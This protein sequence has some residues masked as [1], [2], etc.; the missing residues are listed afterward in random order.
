MKA[1]EVIN[2][3]ATGERD[4][5]GANLRGLSFKNQDLSGAD[6]SG[7]DIRSTNFTGA[8]LTGAKFIEAQA[9]LQKRW[10]ILLVLLSWLM[11]FSSSVFS[12]VITIWIPFFFKPELDLGNVE[13]TITSAIY[14]LIMFVFLIATVGRGLKSGAIAAVGAVIVT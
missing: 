12:W 13:A 10:V 11:A 8:N 1:S 5:R 7:A 14:L 2:K 9:G 4:F 6:F 3:Y